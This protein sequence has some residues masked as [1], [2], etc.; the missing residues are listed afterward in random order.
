LS[1]KKSKV[2]KKG[3]DGISIAPDSAE[4]QG[5]CMLVS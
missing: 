3:G 1:S 5:W 4:L 2:K